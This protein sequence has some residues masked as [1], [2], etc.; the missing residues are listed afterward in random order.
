MNLP[1]VS[2]ATS[3]TYGRSNDMATATPFLA[4]QQCVIPSRGCNTLRALVSDFFVANPACYTSSS[5]LCRRRKTSEFIDSY[6]VAMILGAVTSGIAVAQLATGIVDGSQELLKF[7][8][9]IRTSGYRKGFRGNRSPWPISPDFPAWLWKP[10]IMA[11]SSGGR[12]TK[13]RTLS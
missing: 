1:I 6:V 13:P 10:C 8:C 4:N 2:S 11:W 9:E 5:C 12:R 3:R 7:W